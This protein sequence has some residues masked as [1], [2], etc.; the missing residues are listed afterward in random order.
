MSKEKQ[1]SVDFVDPF[2]QLPQTCE[3][4]ACIGKQGDE[5][6]YVDGY[7][8]AALDLVNSVIDNKQHLKIDRLAMPIL[9]NA[10]HGIELLLK[11]TIR[12]LNSAQII[13]TQY[14]MDH[15]IAAHLTSLNSAKI[16]DHEIHS[17]LTELAPFVRSL[18]LIDRDGQEFRY[19]QNRKGQKSLSDY[20]LVNLSVVRGSLYRL[21]Q[22]SRNLRRRVRD[23]CRE[24]GTGFH[25]SRLSTKDL[26]EIAQELP[27]RDDWSKREFLE[28]SS[29]IRQ[30]YNLSK[31]Q[32]AVALSKIE[33]NRETASMIGIESDLV[34]LSDER[35]LFLARRWTEINPPDRQKETVLSLTK[36]DVSFSLKNFDTR[37]Y[38]N[39]LKTLESEI[40]VDEFADAETIFYMSRDGDFSEFYEAAFQ[41]TKLEIISKIDV[42]GEASRVMR[43]SNFL[44][45]FTNGVRRLGRLQL[46]K[47]LDDL[48][49]EYDAGDYSPREGG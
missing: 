15:D 30:I 44:I 26:Y 28:I 14:N 8:T 27:P 1:F 49:R 4:N 41:E 29:R 2:F 6:D 9:Y 12:R 24:R 13:H 7:M 36:H 39:Q 22:I 18:A 17:L 33:Q 19:H 21:S 3:W 23:F 31:R 34:H 46:H 48:L 38:A 20:S 5:D 47:K 45:Q 42:V 11:F 37:Y 43:K 40:S 32:Y 25:T 10:R 16:P 35:A